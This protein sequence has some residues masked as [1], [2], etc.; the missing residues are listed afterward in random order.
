M[1]ELFAFLPALFILLIVGSRLYAA[2]KKLTEKQ[3]KSIYENPGSSEGNFADENGQSGRE[4]NNSSDGK[5]LVDNAVRK[6]MNSKFENEKSRQRKSEI[7]PENQAEEDMINEENQEMAAKGEEQS[8]EISDKS[9]IKEKSR[10]SRR[11][12][13]QTVEDKGKDVFGQKL[14]EDDLVK[15]IIF[16]EILDEPRARRP[17]N[18]THRSKN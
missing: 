14:S 7:Y 10:K 3:N 1:E 13:K 2:F 5:N 12:I 17:Y 8:E 15:G 6:Y 16:K 9:V 11:K 4:K 18:P